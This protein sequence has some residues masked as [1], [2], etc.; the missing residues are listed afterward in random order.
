LHSSVAYAV[1]RIED[2]RESLAAALSRLEKTL[3]Y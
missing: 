2:E 1:R 3:G